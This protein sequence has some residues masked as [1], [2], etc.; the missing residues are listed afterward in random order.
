MVVALLIGNERSR[1]T[2]SENV[3]KYVCFG[4]LIEGGN[5]KDLDRV[6]YNEYLFNNRGR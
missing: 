2:T 1:F 3:C 6:S 5:D 4:S